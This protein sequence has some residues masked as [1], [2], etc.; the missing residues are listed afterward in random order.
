[1]FDTKRRN[2][3]ST[4]YAACAAGTGFVA[5]VA[6]VCWLILNAQGIY[7]SD[8]FTPMPINTGVCFIAVS[9]G[10][11]LRLRW[12]VASRAFGLFVMLVGG[13]TLT[14]FI[15][16]T[17]FGLDHIFWH[18]FGRV[19]DMR[20]ERMAP[21]VAGI[22]TLGG[23]ALVLLSLK[24]I[25]DR[26]GVSVIAVIGSIIVALGTVPFLSRL[27]EASS[28]YGW[29][30]LTFMDPHTSV[31]CILFGTSLLVFVQ[32]ASRKFYW[33]PIAVGIGFSVLSF[34]LSTAVRSQENAKIDLLV[35]A[36]TAEIS[37][38]IDLRLG[39]IFGSLDRMAKRWN[40]ADGLSI[41]LWEQDAQSHVES[42][43]G[44][45]AISITNSDRI[46]FDI[47]PKEENKAVLGYDMKTDPIRTAIIERVLATN[48]PQ[49]SH[50]LT[51][52]TGQPGFL[53]FNPLYDHDKFSGLLLAVMHVDQFFQSVLADDDDVN[54]FDIT[55]S[56]NGRPVFSSAASN[57]SLGA[58]WHQSLNN[59]NFG[60]AWAI[61]V[62]PNA[63]FIKAHHSFIATAV[64]MAGVITA[65]LLGLCTYLA[66]R[67]HDQS[68]RLSKSE[69]LNNAILFNAGSCII[70]F[71]AE[72]MTLV[73]NREAE[74]MLGYQA[75][76]IVGHF[77]PALWHDKAEMS[78]RAHDLTIELGRFIEPGF[79][80]FTAIAKREGS[81]T[82][83]WTF[84]RHDRS[85][86][87]V[88]LTVTPLFDEKGVMK[89]F[90]S[91]GRDITI[92][93]QQQEALK[94][95]E[96]L[97]NAILSY[98]GYSI[99]ATNPEGIILLYNREA[100]RLLGYAADEV[101]GKQTP[102][103]WHD[104]GE[105]L[106]LALE[107][108]R[109]AG[110]EVEPGMDAFSYRPLRDGFETRQWTFE[111]KDG[112]RFPVQL[113]VT[114]LRDERDRVIGYIGIG[115]DITWQKQQQL[116]LELSE[117]TFRT[118]MENAST[119]MALVDP[120]GQW[121][122]VNR[123]LCTMLGYTHDELMQLN[124]RDVTCPEDME[125][126]IH[127]L[128]DLVA[129][130][131][132]TFQLQKRYIRKDRQIVWGLLNV[133]IVRNADG[134]PNYMVSQIVDINR[135]REAQ[136]ALKT[137]EATF[138]SAMDNSSIGMALATEDGHFI[139]FNDALCEM[140][141]Y[142]RVDLMART[143]PEL[144]H[145]DDLF[146]TMKNV[147][148]VVSGARNAY[149]VD[150]RYI[151]ADGQVVWVSVNSSGVRKPDGSLNYFVVQV[152]NI[153]FQKNQQRALK[154]SEETFRAAMENASIG[155]A[156]VAP[157]GR[158]LR[159]NKALCNLFGYEEGELTK[160]NIKDVT[161][162]EDIEVS[163]A[164]IKKIIDGDVKAYEIEKRYLRKNG[165]GIW[166]LLN[167][168]IVRHPDGSP[169]YLIAQIHDISQRKEMEDL[170]DEFVSIVSHELRTPLT[171]IRGSLGL[172][173]G[174]LSKDLSPQIGRLVNIAHK[175]A[176]RL[177]LLINDI[178]DIDKIAAGK[179]RFDL[180]RENVHALLHQAIDA[181]QSYADKFNVYLQLTEIDDALAIDVDPDRFMQALS[182]LLSNAAKFSL[183]G[184]AVKVAAFAHSE[185]I[186]F[187]VA[188]T[189]SGI[190]E[191]FKARIFG[192][193]LQADSSVKRE[194]GGTGLGLHIT[195]EI[196]MHM[197]GQIGFQSSLGQGATFWIDFPNPNYV[198]PSTS[199]KGHILI[200]EDDK[201]VAS[202]LKLQIED[203]GYTADVVFTISDARWNLQTKNYMAM[204]LDLGFP[205]ENG[206]D[207]INE[208]R[209]NPA[210]QHLPVV[211]VS[212][213][214]DE[215]RRL[216]GDAVGVMDWLSKPVDEGRLVSALQ[217]AAGSGGHVAKMRILHVEDDRD[218]SKVLSTALRDKAE[219][220]NVTTL[221]EAKRKL[222]SEAFSL[223]IIDIAMPDGNGLSLLGSS[224][225]CSTLPIPVI[226]LSA[227]EAPLAIQE[228]VSAAMVKSRMSET[229]IVD[230]I[231]SLIPSRE[232]KPK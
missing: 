34:S 136:E 204:T 138:R 170:K 47:M 12:T 178:L 187:V 144:T 3:S 166:T 5:V 26:Q 118:A 64:L 191:E 75:Y 186:R 4:L 15:T 113:T 212:A 98:A 134:S 42:F 220:I 157:D 182:N 142:E 96:T 155:M 229:K 8:T 110:R 189:G 14:Q 48:K 154:T 57:S 232:G 137:S 102:A 120:K 104:K 199:S 21:N 58:Q 67:W 132:E 183:P 216:V 169:N 56:E 156:L 228:R 116:D 11:L 16:E 198:L 63:R 175:N 88:L 84:I 149:E 133:S 164:N 27:V 105:I 131:I 190:P 196:V 10:L 101:I 230:T 224:D 160:M 38:K 211:V 215:G 124:V 111:R 36:E 184:S 55:I 97:N 86:F 92:Q 40:A 50:V 146:L 150:K 69:T 30:H 71:D 60:M 221:K 207:F 46:L 83:E 202:I 227:D 145:P 108:S 94:K 123:A 81:E 127:N 158:W 180:K 43:A 59:N 167:V 51:L 82:R 114:P 80:V 73:F 52:K 214:A 162:P 195:R 203:M 139:R 112:Y 226:I 188:D 197:G 217:L 218:L 22:F 193:F 107:T 91:I 153:T 31:A 68:Q 2:L 128:L 53:Y 89:G 23:F 17:N 194:K 7:N 100:E 78:A 117:Q 213:E 87:P 95:S 143:I 225:Q 33:L 172:I 177:I 119:G 77:T 106:A 181:N 76:E 13:A 222:R 223:V 151:R 85:R 62:E 37:D 205:E 185:N 208:L 129:G 45:S 20:A 165:V 163:L 28:S 99:V 130:R 70:A 201:N 179:M 9:V 32:R 41:P 61:D 90:I 209:R 176:E 18:V 54:Q 79:D 19:L 29:G 25:P 72:G 115:Q 74:R 171:S 66:L 49:T 135:Q 93:K 192:K 125:E 174:A 161:F 65:L 147:D 35:Q 168:S 121:L 44:L 141:G 39:S 1:M 103:L 6:V 231:M 24:R 159:V 140:L 173:T 122:R 210:T 200:C 126:T 109:E 152:R 148:S 206:A 219:I